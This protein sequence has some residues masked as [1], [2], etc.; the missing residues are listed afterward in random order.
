[1]LQ[2]PLFPF[3]KFFHPSPS[4]FFSSPSL[5]PWHF[6]QALDKEDRITPEVVRG[7][8]SSR[9]SRVNP[10]TSGLTQEGRDAYRRLTGGRNRPRSSRASSSGGVIDLTGSDEEAAREPGGREESDG[11]DD[12]DVDGA[13]PPNP[14]MEEGGNMMLPLL[15][16]LI[17]RRL[18]DRLGFGVGI[19]VYSG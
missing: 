8:R 2:S 17:S 5:T 9:S 7:R 12:D 1:M 3:F 16:Y 14:E 15:H 13:A 6:V 11:E 4:S 19:R 10:E 18:E